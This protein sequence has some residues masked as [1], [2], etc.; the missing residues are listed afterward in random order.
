MKFLS[1]LTDIHVRERRD[2]YNIKHYIDGRNRFT[3]LL[4]SCDLLNDRFFSIL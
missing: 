3:Y 4:G 2:V 1:E